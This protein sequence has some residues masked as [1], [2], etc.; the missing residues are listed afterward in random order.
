VN[1]DRTLATRSQLTAVAGRALLALLTLSGRSALDRLLLEDRSFLDLLALDLG[2]TSLGTTVLEVELL[3]KLEVELDGGALELTLESVRDGDVDLGTVEGT[4]TRVELPLG[5]ATSNELIKSLGKL[6]LGLIPGSNIAKMTLGTGRKLHLEGETELAIDSAEEIEE[7]KN[8]R[9]DLVLS[10][11]DV[12]VVLLEATDSGETGESTRSLVTVEDTKV[13]NSH[14]QFSVTALTVREE[15]TVTRAVHGLQSP[16]VLLNL[17]G[18][19]VILVM[20]PVARLLPQGRVVHVGRHDLLVAT[21]PVLVAEEA[22]ESVVDDHTVRKEEAGTGG[23][24]VEEEELLLLTD[25][26]VIALGSLFEVL[27]VLD[28]HGLVGEGNTVDTL[29]RVVLGITE[30]VGGRVLLQ[31]QFAV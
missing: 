27:L 24:V 8:L 10:T 5:T 9:L 11:E 14:G 22:L 21:A 3:R 2:F 19:H 17:E 20:L 23:H 1:H 13:G 4:V 25:L 15:Q 12:G 30:E 28:H 7:T 31:C 6:S 18:E 26:A 16:L 29:K